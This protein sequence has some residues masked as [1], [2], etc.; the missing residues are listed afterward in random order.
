MQE[1][2]EGSIAAAAARLQ[3]DGARREVSNSAREAAP[4]L[5][6]WS[7]HVLIRYPGRSGAVHVSV[8]TGE[9]VVY[10]VHGAACRW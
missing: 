1:V 8:G 3:E 2:P 6:G 10:T 4:A 9:V 5:H 7:T